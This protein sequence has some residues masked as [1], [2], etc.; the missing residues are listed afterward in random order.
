MISCIRPMRKSSCI[1]VLIVL[2]S[3]VKSD[4][5]N[6]KWDVN[7]KASRVNVDALGYSYQSF[8]STVTKYT[9]KGVFKVDYTNL[10]NGDISSVDARNALKL[11]L[12]YQDQQKI[13]LLDNMLGETNSVDLTSYFEWTDLVCLSNRDNGF[14]LYS[15]TDQSLI[16]ADENL[17]VKKKFQNIGQLLSINLEPTQLFEKDEL[18]YLFD[19]SFGTLIFDLFGNYKKKIPL[20]NVT[21]IMVEGDYL[22]SLKGNCIESFN[23]KSFDKYEVYCSQ[24]KVVDFCISSGSLYLQGLENLTKYQLKK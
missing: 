18:V 6:F 20:V 13:V 15:I 21:K 9:T 23:M 12:F 10:V 8:K 5:V 11:M 16:K 1:L 19:P 17:E 24:V 22:Y 4:S 7:K 3:F 14:W 2:F